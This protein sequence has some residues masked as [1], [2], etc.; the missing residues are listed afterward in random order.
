MDEQTPLTVQYEMLS[1]IAQTLD[2]N[3][4]QAQTEEVDCVDVDLHELEEMFAEYLEQNGWW[5]RDKT[6]NRGTHGGNQ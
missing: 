2:E 3:I 1:A 5:P 4:R 6:P